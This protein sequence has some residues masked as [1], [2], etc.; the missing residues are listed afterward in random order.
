M[1]DKYDFGKDDG[2]NYYYS[3]QYKHR[4]DP[5]WILNR[6]HLHNNHSNDTYDTG[7]SRDGNRK[8][9]PN[10][11]LLTP[12][13]RTTNRFDY[14]LTSAS[15]NKTN[16]NNNYNNNQNKLLTT[17]HLTNTSFYFN[18][19]FRLYSNYSNNN[20]NNNNSH[21]ETA[22]TSNHGAELKCSRWVFDKSFYE[23][24]LTEEVFPQFIPIIQLSFHFCC[25]N[26]SRILCY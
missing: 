18:D 6:E 22:Y 9:S 3:N 17:N 7:G 5:L 14:H 12:D 15:T 19:K 23:K 8:F 24:T 10:A 1:D 21:H 2:L 11:G 4:C 13:S 16:P 20:N 26:K 25:F